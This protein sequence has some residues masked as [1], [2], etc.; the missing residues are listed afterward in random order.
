V[1]SDIVPSGILPWRSGPVKALGKA[2]KTVED[3]AKPEVHGQP[4][5]DLKG[6]V[7]GAERKPRLQ[8]KIKKVS[9]QHSRQR[10]PETAQDQPLNR[11]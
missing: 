5:I 3:K 2:Q 11:R 6:C 7:P 9:R 10:M 8:R 4:P 1:I